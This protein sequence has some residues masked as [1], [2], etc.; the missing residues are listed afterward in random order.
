MD[1]FL[2]TGQMIDQLKPGE[3]AEAV[4]GTCN[5]CKV[6]KTEVNEIIPHNYSGNF[7]ELTTFAMNTMWRITP[8]F[9]SFNEAI[10]AYQEGKEIE[11]YLHDLDNRFADY[12]NCIRNANE[13]EIS[14]DEILN[15]KWLIKN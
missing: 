2:T 1:E 10:E 13:Q 5:G 15:G 3:I 7:M 6:K 12:S 8:E 14:I 9:V 4:K 11:S